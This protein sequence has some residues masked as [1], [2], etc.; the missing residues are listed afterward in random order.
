MKRIAWLLIAALTMGSLVAC[1]GDQGANTS[2]PSGSGSNPPAQSTGT[3]FGTTES[4]GNATTP[5]PQTTEKPATT[6]HSGD[7]GPVGPELD[8]VSFPGATAG[9]TV[10]E[11]YCPYGEFDSADGK[12]TSTMNSSLFVVTNDRMSAGKLTATFTSKEG[13]AAND[14]GIVFGMEENIDDNYYFWEEAGYAAPYYFLFVGDNNCLILA[15]VAYGQNAWEGL[16]GSQPV[17]GYAHGGTV[18]VSVEFDGQGKILCYANGEL[19]FEYTDPDGPR[20]G[21]YG[22]RCEVEGVVFDSLI[23]EHA[24]E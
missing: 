2:G 17:I 12:I 14:N 9:D 8:R 11:G 24:E 1:S 23:A 6:D 13:S 19:L 15:K 16:T 10:L 7:P 21:R 20:G 5:K 18:T 4:P 3:P 22:V